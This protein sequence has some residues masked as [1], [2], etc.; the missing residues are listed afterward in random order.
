MSRINAL[1]EEH[2]K[3]FLLR[4][5]ERKKKIAL[6]NTA[7]NIRICAEI[8]RKQALVA[9]TTKKTT[10]AH[11]VQ[12]SRRRVPA[13]PSWTPV[14]PST[15]VLVPKAVLGAT[16]AAKIFMGRL[17]VPHFGTTPE[18]FRRYAEKIGVPARSLALA[19]VNGVFSMGSDGKCR[20]ASG[21]IVPPEWIRGTAKGFHKALMKYEGRCY[22]QMRSAVKADPELYL[23]AGEKSAYKRYCEKA[24]KLAAVRRLLMIAKGQINAQK[25]K[26]AAAADLE[27]RRAAGLTRR[28][29]MRRSDKARRAAYAARLAS[30]RVH[31]ALKKLGQ[32]MAK[33]AAPQKAART[34]PPPSRVLEGKIPE[35]SLRPRLQLPIREL[36]SRALNRREEEPCWVPNDGSDSYTRGRTLSFGAPRRSTSEE[37]LPSGDRFDSEEVKGFRIFIEAQK[38]PLED[39]YMDAFRVDKCTTMHEVT[40]R[41]SLA[42]ACVRLWKHMPSA[43]YFSNLLGAVDCTAARLSLVV[44]NLWEEIRGIENAMGNQNAHGILSF[45][46]LS[47]AGI[48]GVVSG[49]AAAV[50]HTAKTTIDYASEAFRKG[51]DLA[52]DT[53]GKATKRFGDTI[54]EV[55]HEQ[56]MKCVSPMLATLSRA[57]AEI[58]NYWRRVKEWASTMWSKVCIEVQALYDSAWWAIALIMVSGLILLTERLL[59]SLGL[60]STTGV[61]VGM[62]IAL[63]L[64]YIGWDLSTANS[65]HEATIV[66]SIR[67]VVYTIFDATL[68]IGAIPSG[69][70]HMC[71]AGLDVLELPLKVMNVV[72][73]GLISA[74]LGTLQ[75]LGR[76]G[77]AMDQIRKGKD[78]MKEFLSF[79]LDRV[80]DA[81][82]YVSGRKES[83][84]RELASLSRVDIV[85]WISDAQ[86]VVL[87]AQTIAVSDPML[88]DTVTHLL[89]KGHQLSVTLAGATR[90]T[91]LDYGRVVSSLVKELTDVRRACARA[92]QCEGRR[93]EPFWV[94]IYGPS[95]CGKSLLMEEVSRLLLIEFG[96]APDD[97]FARNARDPFWSHY[98]QQACVCVDDLS[99]CETTPSFESEFMQLVGSKPYPL[100]MAECADKGMA[101]NSS[102]IVSTSNVFTAP[103]VAKVLDREAYN[104]RRGAVIQCRKARGVQFNP[105]DPQASTEARLVNPRDESPL[106][107]P[108]GQWRNC[109]ATFEEVIPIANAHRSKELALQAFWKG[110]NKRSNPVSAAAS[111]F[112]KKAAERELLTEFAID[113]NVYVVDKLAHDAKISTLSAYSPQLESFSVMLVS[114]LNE[115]IDADAYQ[116]QL[117]AFLH[118]LVEGPCY[119]EGVDRLNSESTSGQREFFQSLSL[120]ERCYIRMV[121]KKM[122][123]MKALPELLFKVDVK[124]HIL[125]CLSTGYNTVIKHGGKFLAIFAAILC[126]YFLFT[127]FFSMYQTFVAGT[128]GAA[129][130]IGLMSQLHAHAGTMSSSSD[131]VSNRSAN[132][133]IYYR[134]VGEFRCHA[135]VP[136][137]D[138]FLSDLLVALITPGGGVI[139]CIR[140]KGRSI[141]LTKHQAMQIPEGARIQVG[142]LSKDGTN[143]YINIIWSRENMREFRDTEAVVYCDP[144]LS[145]LPAAKQ[146]VFLD[147]V[148][149]LPKHFSLNATVMKQKR[150]MTYVPTELSSLMPNDII[151]NRWKSSGR[152]NTSVQT[153]DTFAAGINYKNDLPRS[154]VSNAYTSP[155]DC[156]AIM[157][158]VFKGRRVVVGMHVAG[159]EE[160]NK[161]TGE[162]TSN[163]CSTACLLPN[164]NDATCHASLPF[165]EEAGIVTEG[166]S[167]V[168]WL[169]IADRPYLSG[170]TAFQPV[171]GD[172]LYDTPPIIEKIGDLEKEVKIELKQPAILSSNDCRIPEGKF[173]DP[174]VNGME[175]FS[176][177][178]QVLDQ[179]LVDEIF[180]DVAD[181]WAEHFDKLEDVSDEVAI[182]GCGDV[183]YDALVMSTSEGYPWVLHRKT[184]ESGK[185]R[186]FEESHVP[187]QLALCAGPVKDSY[188]KLQDTCFTSV[189]QL[190]CI[191]TPKDECLPERKRFKTRLFSILPLEFNLFFRKKFLSFCASLQSH[192]HVLPTQV[193]VNPYSREWQHLYERIAAQSD[194]AANCDYS[195][196]DG[197][198]NC[199][200]LGAMA[201]AINLRFGDS[202]ASK[203]QRK[204][205]LLSITNR[206]SIAGNQVFEVAAGIPSGCALTVLLNSI[207]NEFLIRYVWKTTIPSVSR[208]SFSRFVTLIV[209]GDDNIIAV[210]PDFLPVFNGGLIKE[211][212]RD[213]GVTITDGTDKSSPTIEHKPLNQLDFLKRRFNVQANGQVF[214]PLAFSSIYTSLHHVTMGA[215]S[216]GQAVHDNV[217]NALMELFLHQRRDL[218]DDMRNF[219]SRHYDDLHSWREMSAFHQEQITGCLP[220]MPHR[221]L[222]VPIHGQELR[223]AMA[224]QGSTAFSVALLPQ[225]YVVGNSFRSESVDD[226]I[227]SIDRP[228]AP[229]ERTRGV[230]HPI[231]FYAQGKGRL[232]TQN[233]VHDFRRPKTIIRTLLYE[234]YKSGHNLFFRSSAPFVDNWCAAIAFAQG[235]GA[236]YTA[237]V[238]LYHNVCTPDA[239]VIYKYFERAAQAPLPK[240]ETGRYRPPQLRVG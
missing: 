92:G 7:E 143:K 84:F 236:D 210:H 111:T 178:M 77:Q 94:Y 234:K 33:E 154:I 50:S 203:Q 81:F 224:S 190:V 172:L 99:A 198:I 117:S 19:F 162:P 20:T 160:K 182:N 46:A 29:S 123:Q 30:D 113:G 12:P 227:I 62:F 219:F 208:E 31:K 73:N 228:L 114:Q 167:K 9:A 26:A 32:R 107:G 3:V 170:K 34:T 36:S 222:D 139:S 161:K 74:P 163:F 204:N 15:R 206:W 76:Y 121:Q 64:G 131:R 24:A 8:K 132:L 120:L 225:V 165:I 217:Q 237:M 202:A 48:A 85:R 240:I 199:Q 108:A 197:L 164:Y 109:M 11:K 186:F 220:W 239:E 2:R 155:F 93:P 83:F 238:N 212:L 134:T 27:A 110:R 54:F 96:H 138:E 52:V 28:A 72:G 221:F 89:Y 63:V 196:F 141:L 171:E 153:I 49:T 183:F 168:G 126:F 106:E 215:G 148:G 192:R 25:R 22:A 226:F 133:P 37:D 158:T 88:M 140:F 157:S 4:E 42:D 173:Y 150:Y 230:Y 101:F 136:D 80:A 44:S 115:T 233:W 166:Y 122:D 207:F 5:K 195:S 193:G 45:V 35:G 128:A 69:N 127:T 103:T 149:L 213:I 116:G 159:A 57:R 39:M 180:H 68:P 51:C 129:G 67:A 13:L 137:D 181:S 41:I 188:E 40:L 6:R 214:A 59:V 184:G 146:S 14:D 142:Y 1:L 176:N 23:T 156:G 98:L 90:S 179:E 229:S 223:K 151:I 177:P 205:L 189:P 65:D 10:V 43:I 145:P 70:S 53:V 232:P 21:T 38:L 187:G 61:L 16:Q 185:F 17:D 125:K 118:S 100:M 130:G 135:G 194:V 95:H 56:F 124:T 119:V 175:K 231:A 55:V 102:L 105:S 91:S 60:M 191:E 18:Q 200:I 169:K 79:C 211:K 174:L 71:H 87:Q 78:A 209:Y 66:A 82:D 201:D 152:L 86:R 147:D 104:N 216:M 235:V 97:I 47:A 112:L 144:K 218:F 58:E 75:W